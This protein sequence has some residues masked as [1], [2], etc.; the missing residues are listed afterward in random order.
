MNSLHLFPPT[1][2]KCDKFGCRGGTTVNLL[3]LFPPTGNKCDKFGVSA[4][5]GRG[6]ARARK[7]VTPARL[8]GDRRIGPPAR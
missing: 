2:N 8:R 6:Q 7:G 4:E 5:M 1:G 3:Q